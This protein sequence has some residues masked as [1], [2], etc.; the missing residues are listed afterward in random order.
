MLRDRR[1]L[2]LLVAETVST[3]GTQM[4]WLALPWFV[5][6]TTGSAGK[7]TLVLAS[8]AVG[9]VSM[10]LP[11]GTILT[12]L[13]PRWTM[14]IA[15][16]ARAPFMLIIPLLYWSGALTFPLLLGL[17]FVVGAVVEFRRHVKNEYVESTV[18]EQEFART[19]ARFSGQHR[20][21]VQLAHHSLDAQPVGDVTAS[22]V[23]NQ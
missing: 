9:L 23:D 8:E 1:L 10:G 22:Q 11:G 7:M 14:M 19:R 12:R 6:T 4:T 13:G 5:L 20:N 18:A 2:A 3:T 16:G 17:V 21:I 15:D